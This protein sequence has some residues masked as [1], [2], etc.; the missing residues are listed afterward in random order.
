MSIPS[1]STSKLP[2]PGALPASTPDVPRDLIEAADL[3]ST[4]IVPR[5]LNGANRKNGINRLRETP[6]KDPFSTFFAK[7]KAKRLLPGGSAHLVALN[8][9]RKISRTNYGRELPPN[10]N[11]RK[12]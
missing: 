12:L 4:I 10:K 8:R 5:D 6:K 3:T 7:A 9:F 1:D 2:K 11:P